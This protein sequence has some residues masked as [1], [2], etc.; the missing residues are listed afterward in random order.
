MNDIINA[1]VAS[2]AAFLGLFA[3]NTPPPTLSAALPAATAVFETS[4]ASPITSSATSMTLAANAVR[5]GGALSGFN[6]FSVDEGSAQAE[7]ICGTVSGTSVTS[8]TRGISQ[9]TGTTTVAALQFSHRRGANV[10]ITDFPVIQILKA[11][12]NGEDTFNNPLKY[13]SIAT[14]TL[15]D[16][17][18]NIPSWGLVLDTALTGAGAV[19]A[20]ETAQGYVEQATQIEVASSTPTGGTGA[21]L[22]I[23]ASAATSTYNSATA[24]LRVVVTKNSGKIDDYFISTSTLLTNLD[25][26]TTTIIGDLPAWSIG[27]QMQAFTSTGTTTFSVPSGI[28]KVSVTVVGGGAGGGSCSVAGSAAGAGGG[29]GGGGTA[30]ENV[31]VTGTTTIQ[32]YVAPTGGAGANGSWS[33][34]GT[35]GFYLYSTGGTAGVSE[36]SGGAGGVGVGGDLNIA[37]SGGGSGIVED[38]SNDKFESGAGGGTTLGG[39]GIGVASNNNGVAGG[40]GG[41]YGGG[42]GGGACEN[43]NSANGG[44]G[45]QGVVIVRW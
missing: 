15:D 38:A 7:T 1:I 40:D 16:D 5:G 44:T 19:G 23:P 42:G 10:K 27:K 13:N 11:Q 8:L 3:G 6:C 43:S 28:T 26:A 29:G 45:A 32:V 21:N 24:P 22:Y 34:F 20:S 18:N 17:R 39:G 2:F 36:G 4:L 35:N 9:A 12:N 30:I 14:T 37:G 41:N 31:D 25:L 33:T